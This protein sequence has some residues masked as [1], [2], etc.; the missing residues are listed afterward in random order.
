MTEKTREPAFDFVLS[1][2][3]MLQGTG[4]GLA[5]LAFAPDIARAATA[6]VAQP[7]FL[8]K[9]D[10]GHDPSAVPALDGGSIIVVDTYDVNKTTGSSAYSLSVPDGERQWTYPIPDGPPIVGGFATPLVTAAGIFL[11]SRTQVIALDPATG[12]QLWA[13]DYTVTETDGCPLVDLGTQIA[14]LAEGGA[15]VVLEQEDG[16]EAWTLVLSSVAQ[17]IDPDAPHGVPVGTSDGVCVVW[18]GHLFQVQFE[19]LVAHAHGIPGT[20]VPTLVPGLGE[21]YYVTRHADGEKAR[22]VALSTATWTETWSIEAASDI[23]YSVPTVAN[24]VLYVGDSSG[25]FFAVTV[26]QSD[27]TGGAKSILWTASPGDDLSDGRI[28]ISDGFAYVAG[29]ASSGAKIIAI[30]LSPSTAGSAHT[31]VRIDAG[32]TGAAIVG[33]DSSVCYFSKTDK[34]ARIK[35]QGV[36]LAGLFAQF[37]TESQLMADHYA[38]ASA[39]GD[40]ATQRPTPS[41]PTYRTQV[42]CVH[43]N[44][45]PRAG[46]TVKIWASERTTVTIGDR[47]HKIGPGDPLWTRTDG[48]GELSLTSVAGG[49]SAPAL[50]MWAPFMQEHEAMVVYPDQ[51]TLGAVASVS[52]QDLLN[53]SDF[54]GAKPIADAGYTSDKATDLATTLKNTMGDTT[55][56]LA[57]VQAG[58]SPSYIAFAGTASNLAFQST[59]GPADRPYRQ[60]SGAWYT[61]FDG[62]I[63]TYHDGT[64]PA[65]LMA[66]FTKHRKNGFDR[67]IDNVVHGHRKIRRIIWTAEKDAKHLVKQIHDDAGDWYN[68]VVDTVEKAATVVAGIFKTV[69]DDI[70]KV[71]EAFCQLFDWAN[72]VAR[73]QKISTSITTAIS[74]LQSGLKTQASDFTTWVSGNQNASTAQAIADTT[75]T[76][77]G[78]Q[79]DFGNPQAFYG[80]HGAKSYCSSRWASGKVSHGSDGASPSVGADALAALESH[81][82]SFKQHF[83]SAISEIEP[84]LRADAA[85]LDSELKETFHTLERLVSHPSQYADLALSEL[86]QSVVDLAELLFTAVV[87]IAETVL[88]ALVDLV[89]D[90]LGILGTA[91]HI[92]VLTEVFEALVPNGEK[93]TCLNLASLLIAIPTEIVIAT[94]DES[95]LG[96]DEKL[97]DGQYAFVFASIAYTAADVAIDLTDGKKLEKNILAL[98]TYGALALAEIG[99]G[100][101]LQVE[102]YGGT[103]LW[104]IMQAAQLIPLAMIIAPLAVRPSDAIPGETT[105]FEYIAVVIQGFYAVFTSIASGMA[106]SS[107]V[108]GFAGGLTLAGNLLTYVPPAFAWAPLA[109]EAV[110]SAVLAGIDGVGDLGSMATTIASWGTE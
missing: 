110:G 1:R 62:A 31:P 75:N 5:G 87:L 98:G 23:D 10:A 21:L 50:Y 3:T 68:L 2:R 91:L 101:G 45:S 77:A 79:Q 55:A 89:D 100:F 48:M 27:V 15:L 99:I 52:G 29:Q 58:T 96:D 42:L 106:Y 93:L 44:K 18:G 40:G 20:V 61:D 72:I 47:S 67:F 57:A 4:L 104:D 46:S 43:P 39:A 78:G 56:S 105:D 7:E 74:T 65:E 32:F 63:A 66:S 84:I 25:T 90:V 22:V 95:G 51:D 60:T 12:F 11:A 54:S 35:I 19:G 109:N 34:S 24:G 81:A 97:S 36:N 102:Q 53:L 83:E 38:A 37:L 14:F 92:P 13:K 8:Y 41:N 33:V 30:P 86:L 103:A 76:T 69:I 80:M 82:A 49:L 85:K 71:V 107:G 88:D 6:T 9:G 59:V 16:G 94:A 28:V 64:P 70:D 17:P 73:S 108:S 26:G